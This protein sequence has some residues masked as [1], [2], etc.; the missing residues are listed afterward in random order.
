MKLEVENQELQEKELQLKQEGNLIE[1]IH[2]KNSEIERL[3][4]NIKSLEEEV[5]SREEDVKSIEQL[6]AEHSLIEVL[7]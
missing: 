7:K 1:S 3:K 5:L 6:S 4:Q 2:R